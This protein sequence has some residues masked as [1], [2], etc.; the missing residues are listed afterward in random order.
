MTEEEVRLLAT[1]IIGDLLSMRVIPDTCSE[2]QLSTAETYITRRITE[3][4][5]QHKKKV[6][7]P[8]V[9]LP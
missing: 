5:E 8:P 9:H 6:D 4:L 7:E 1:D 3:A 2:R